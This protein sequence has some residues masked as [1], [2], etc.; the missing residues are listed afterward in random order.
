MILQIM[1]QTQNLFLK[2]QLVSSIFLKS[3]LIFVT[4]LLLWDAIFKTKP[5]RFL[6]S[7][8][9]FG[10]VMILNFYWVQRPFRDPVLAAEKKNRH[11]NSYTKILG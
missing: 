4:F 1:S 3:C 11:E 7:E 5:E 2:K 6:G 9:L 10:D 8:T